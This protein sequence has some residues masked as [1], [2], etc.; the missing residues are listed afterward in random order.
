MS[1]IDASMNEIRFMFNVPKV[2]TKLNGAHQSYRMM[3][4][5]P[6]GRQ[7]HMSG[8]GKVVN[9]QIIRFG[10]MKECTEGKF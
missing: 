10:C 1:N 2:S 7:S 3:R 8:C 9:I 4:I 6:G 5:S